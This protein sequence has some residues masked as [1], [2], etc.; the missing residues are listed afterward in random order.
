MEEN[1]HHTLCALRRLTYAGL[2][3]NIGKCEFLVP[4]LKMLGVFLWNDHYSLGNKSIQRL[5]GSI[6]PS[7]LKELQGLLG[8]L[9]YA[10]QFI[11]DY[12][13]LVKPLIKL[14]SKNGG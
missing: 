2:P 10:S 12:K 9:N 13:R 6:L 8:K 14:L 11:P 4:R 5:Y 7:S 3:V 1:W